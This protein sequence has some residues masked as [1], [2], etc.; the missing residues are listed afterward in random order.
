MK[1]IV[2]DLKIIAI[3]RINGYFGIPNGI[4]KAPH[5]VFIVDK[6]IPKSPA[7]NSMFIFG[8]ERSYKAPNKPNAII[9]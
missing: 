1:N 8:F 4:N 7:H 2:K 6:N 9:N 3:K 5:I